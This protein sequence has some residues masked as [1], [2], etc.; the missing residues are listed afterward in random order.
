MDTGPVS[1]NFAAQAPSWWH[2]HPGDG[3]F[4]PLAK[5]LVSAEREYPVHAL[6]QTLYPGSTRRLRLP[7]V[8]FLGFHF[9]LVLY[10]SR[11]AGEDYVSARIVC[12]GPARSSGIAVDTPISPGVRTVLALGAVSGSS[13]VVNLEKVL[14]QEDGRFFPGGGF[15]QKLMRFRALMVHEKEDGVV[16]FKLRL[17]PCE[18]LEVSKVTLNAKAPVVAGVGWMLKMFDAPDQSDADVRLQGTGPGGEGKGKILYGHRNILSFRFEFFRALL[19]GAYKERSEDIVVLPNISSDALEVLLRYIYGAPLPKTM[20]GEK[21]GILLEIWQFADAKMMPGLSMECE[22]IAVENVTPSLFCGCFRVARLLEAV[23]AVSTLAHRFHEMDETSEATHEVVETF[24]HIEIC[25]LLREMPVTMRALKLADKW[26]LAA[27]HCVSG[28]D[29]AANGAV[30]WLGVGE[31]DKEHPQSSTVE[32]AEVGEKGSPEGAAAR[33]SDAVEEEMNMT[34]TFGPSDAVC[35]EVVPCKTC[36]K[37]GVLLL[38]CIDVSVLEGAGLSYWMSSWTVA[39]RFASRAEIF[40]V[41]N[42]LS[43]EAMKLQAKWKPSI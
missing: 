38:R 2:G 16:S 34:G 1:L 31:K 11:E 24:T 7:R 19:S 21:Y 43:K 18:S 14:L 37:Y 42:R 32:I 4:A 6:L 20:A 39:K 40:V 23:A 5:E 10:A 13:R 28:V 33:S 41:G 25:A 26:I 3:D 30:C 35:A 17:E 15:S 22:I 9:H 29:P 36:E 8:E 27:S 12:S